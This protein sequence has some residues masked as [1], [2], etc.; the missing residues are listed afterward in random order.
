MTI[1]I[2]RLDTTPEPMI[3]T[4][5]AIL[6]VR[7][8]SIPLSTP[9]P[10][11]RIAL[12]PPA[13]LRLQRLFFAVS[14]VLGPAVMILG[15]LFS[16]TR[17]ANGSAVIA[18]QMTAETGLSPV[19][20]VTTVLA[21]FLLPFGALAMTL[22]AM[23]RSPWL[24]TIGGFLTLSGVVALIVF[25]GQEVLMRLMAGMGGGPQLVILWDRFNTD[26]IITTFLY[27]F[28]IGYL[29]G[30]VLLAIALGRTRLIPIWAAGA[31]ILRTPIQIG[32]FVSHIGLSIEIVT[33]GL[34]LIGSIPIA[35][36]LLSFADEA[37]VV[38]R[39][40]MR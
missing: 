22:L 16:P 5:A 1:Q 29:V 9:W 32:G 11:H 38:P 15:L 25:V 19:T 31:I 3:P 6:S 23:R 12:R 14:L 17:T 30:P 21:L 37:E 24:A 8:A 4:E 27:I 39:S 7:G 28:V 34:L 33:Y 2:H 36:T 13:Y 26:P 10:N 20:F 40:D 35:R 18:A